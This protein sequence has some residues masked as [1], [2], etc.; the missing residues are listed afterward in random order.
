MNPKQVVI[1][2]T[3]SIIYSGSHSRHD[4]D[5]SL[6]RL[7]YWNWICV[8]TGNVGLGSVVLFQTFCHHM[9]ISE[10][11]SL[12]KFVGKFIS[13]GTRLS[14]GNCIMIL[15]LSTLLEKLLISSYTWIWRRAHLKQKYEWVYNKIGR[16]VSN[17]NHVNINEVS[18]VNICFLISSI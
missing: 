18:T 9:A 14:C 15:P 1:T 5:S 7:V 6:A 4:F 2:I 8:A 13:W 11:D 16:T 12:D 10:I 3:F 17:D